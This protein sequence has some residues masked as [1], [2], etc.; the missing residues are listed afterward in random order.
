[1][2]TITNFSTYGEYEEAYYMKHE[3]DFGNQY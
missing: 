1:M 2:L 3:K